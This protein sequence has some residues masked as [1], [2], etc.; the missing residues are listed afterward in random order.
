MLSTIAKRSLLAAPRRHVLNTSATLAPRWK[1]SVTLNENN[2]QE[3]TNATESIPDFNDSKAAFESK[4]T[5]E[6]FRAALCFRLCRIPFLVNH[7]E[8]LLGLSR[9]ILGN[10]VTD[11]I[12]RATLFGHFCAGEDQKRIE[13]VLKKLDSVGVGSILDYA[14][15]SDESSSEQRAKSSGSPVN[16]LNR[17]TARKLHH[18]AREYSY[19]DED[20]CDRHVEV[21]QKCINDAASLSKDGFAAVKVTALGNPKLL[22]RMSQ[23][24]I[25]SKRLFQKFDSNLNGY[26]TR[27]EFEVAYNVFFDKGDRSVDDIFE[28]FDPHNTGMVDYITWSLNLK[29]TDLPK[30]TNSCKEIGPLALATPTDEEIELIEA[31]YE[32]GHTLANTAAETGTR[33]LIDAEQ[34]RFQPA[35]D[36]LVL[37]LQ[38]IHNQVGKSDKPIIYNTYQC[39]L[40]DAPERLRTDLDRAKRFNYH[41]GA[42][43]VRGAYMESERLLAAVAHLPS[44][45]HETIE[46]THACYNDSIDFLLQESTKSAKRKVE[47]MCA[48]HN[49]QSIEKAL[50]LMEKYGVD[51]SKNTVCFGQLFGMSDHLSFNLGRSGYRAY[52]YVP[53]GEVHEVMPYLLRRAREN[54]AIAGGAAAELGMVIDELKRRLNPMR[55]SA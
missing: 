40:K 16:H 32:R 46:D 39:Y 41:F 14:A 27:E 19:E 12:L 30:I 3:V 8:D 31:M 35:I 47:I 51:R 54:S 5:K 7:A 29:P 49:Q 53:Y 50:E 13:P 23:A 22:S 44:P 20:Q 38:Q 15:E 9:R 6:L 52:K 1:S 25:E 21:F 33:L 4:T 17:Q 18:S 55:Q 10:T 11:A 45:I 24:I 48:T 37:D 28:E 2:G 34:T 26:V 43:L 42:K 36:N